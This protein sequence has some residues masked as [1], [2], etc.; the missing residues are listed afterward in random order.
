MSDHGSNF[1]GAL[2]QNEEFNLVREEAS[3]RGISWHLNPVGASHC[4]GVFERK[5][6]S[7]RRVLEAQLL[8]LSTPVSRDELCTLLQEAAAVV[9]STPLY[10]IPDGP[11]EPLA[12]SPSHLLTLK[13]PTPVPSE[14]CPTDLLAY[15]KRRWRK[16]QFLANEF[17]R[18]WRKQYIQGLAQRSKWTKVR[19]NVAVGDVVILRDKNTPRCDWKL[20]VVQRPIPGA[21]GLV[22]KA[23]VTVVSGASGRT[24][25]TEKSIHDMVILFTKDHLDSVPK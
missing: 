13:S 20:A 3:S 23:I 19:R 5:I 10:P 1:I 15:G 18:L 22:R 12:L 2:G 11:D 9:N 8:P 6:G 16:V 17:W 24:R 25:E 7:V 4:G 14:S 21:D